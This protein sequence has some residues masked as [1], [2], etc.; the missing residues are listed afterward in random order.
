[1]WFLVTHMTSYIIT[2]LYYSYLLSYIRCGLTHCYFFRYF[3]HGKNQ[4][5]EK[6]QTIF[7]L[8][9][10]HDM[11]QMQQ[12]N[13]YLD[14]FFLFNIVLK[15]VLVLN[16]IFMQTNKFS[17]FRFNKCLYKEKMLIRYLDWVAGLPNL[18]IWPGDSWFLDFSPDRKSSDFRSWFS[19]FFLISPDF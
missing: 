15:K 4:E 3:L 10:A 2:E 13:V 17:C 14:F 5:R 7:V 11:K 18:L 16:G 6:M 9:R 19:T 12:K 1:M 8:R